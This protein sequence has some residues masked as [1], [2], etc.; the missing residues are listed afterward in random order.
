MSANRDRSSPP[1]SSAQASRSLEERSSVRPLSTDREP[2]PEPVSADGIDPEDWAA[3][4]GKA[5][6]ERYLR[7]RP[8]HWE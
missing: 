4:G 5:D 3:S 7:E 1:G 6:E 8:P 2:S